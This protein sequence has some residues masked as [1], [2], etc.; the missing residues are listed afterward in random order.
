MPTY[1]Y[2]CRDCGEDLEAVQSFTDDPLTECP[3]CKGTLRKVF[4]APGISFK[5]SGFYKT[6][7]RSSS[8]AATKDNAKDKESSADSKAET[9][10]EPSSASTDKKKDSGTKKAEAKTA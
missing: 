9:K 5:G 8:K 4:A 1:Q 7:S 3:N 6:D 2:R 10:S